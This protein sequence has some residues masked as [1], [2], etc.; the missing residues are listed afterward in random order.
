MSYQ[1]LARKW[2]PKI[3][4]DVIGQGHITRSL[5][6]SLTNKK[7]GHAYLFTG[8]RGVGKTTVARIFAKAIRCLDP[9]ADGNPCL[10]CTSCS[11]IENATSMDFTEID[12]ASNNSVDNIRTLIDNVQYLPILGNYKIYVIDEV[13]MLSTNA[14]NA[15]LKTLEEPPAHV[16]FIFATTEV[17][18]LLGTVLSR[19]QRFDFRQVSLM[20]LESHVTKIA[21]VE[22]IKLENNHILREIC[23]QGKGSVRDT[24]SILDQ[25]VSFSIDNNIT[26]EVLTTSL[27]LAKTSAMRDLLSHLVLGNSEELKKIYETLIYEN[28]DLKNITQRIIDNLYESIRL[29]NEPIKIYNEGYFNPKSLDSVTSSELIWIFETLA[30]DF[31][32]ALKSID[33]VKVVEIVLL[34]VALR[35]TFFEQKKNELTLFVDEKLFG[36]TKISFKDG[37]HAFD[38]FIKFLKDKA[39][40]SATNL[41][42]GNVTNDVAI[43]SSSL[44]F[45]IA[46][47]S[48]SQI[49]YDYFK[50]KDA[51]KKLKSLAATFFNLDEDKISIEFI[52]INDQKENFVT[53][54]ELATKKK[55]EEIESKRSTFYNNPHIKEAEKIFNTKIDK[56]ILNE[57]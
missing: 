55:E 40:A 2:R 31:E 42:H 34:K 20:D 23:L 13:H 11:E 46:F 1:V 5:Q 53:K 48:E 4:N 15:L 39:P 21:Q 27:G 33:P 22:K 28:I 47:K 50:D 35:R 30:K 17:E 3:F 36:P 8:T 54:V 43:N 26:E 14:F 49:F 38:E 9:K 37:H 44:F 12:G 51:F 10:V 6:N 57:E 7:L 25:V 41:E 24:L 19:C 32:W 52:L 16:I 29:I 18:K 56:I 45:P